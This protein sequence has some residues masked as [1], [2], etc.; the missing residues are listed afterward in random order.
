V[1]VEERRG[2]DDDG[3]TTLRWRWG[4]CVADNVAQ[5]HVADT[6]VADI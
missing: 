5:W 4:W 3:E 1:G 2:K 6:S